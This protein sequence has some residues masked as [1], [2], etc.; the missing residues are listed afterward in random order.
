VTELDAI[1]QVFALDICRDAWIWL[2]TGNGGCRFQ[3]LDSAWAAC[4]RA[5]WMLWW[6]GK[7]CCY[8]SP[9]HRQCVLAATACAR[10]VLPIWEAW[11]P[12]GSHPREGIEIAEGWARGGSDAPTLEDVQQAYT[13]VSVRAGTIPRLHGCNNGDAAA[14]RAAH[15]AMH[16]GSACA[17]AIGAAVGGEIAKYAETAA[18]AAAQAAAYAGPFDSFRETWTRTHREMAD[19]VRG[20][21]PQP[22]KLACVPAP[23]ARAEPERGCHGR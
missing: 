23:R 8:G 18:A 13:A 17:G 2:H 19:L 7:C 20:F 1:N 5:D 16:A 11:Y 14:L 6:G 21:F 12:Q 4:P 9:E 10:R 3:A 22:P 15:A